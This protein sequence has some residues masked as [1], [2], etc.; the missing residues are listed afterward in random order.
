M[1]QRQALL[2][3]FGLSLACGASQG[4][5]AS[6]IAPHR[7]AQCVGAPESEVGRGTLLR[8][9]DIRESEDDLAGLLF[10]FHVY[11]DSLNGEYSEAAG[12]IGARRVLAGVTTSADNDSISFMLPN[13]PDSSRFVGQVTCDSL[14]GTFWAFPTS[15]GAPARFLRVREDSLLPG[16]PR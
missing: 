7:L 2:A 8:F 13:G 9:T 12:E 5:S 11:P 6:A 14:W 16:A 3:A 1:N 4:S 15:Q 10:E